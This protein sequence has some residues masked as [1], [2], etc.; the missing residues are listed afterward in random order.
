MPCNCIPCAVTTLTNCCCNY[1]KK[2]D[3]IY[4]INIFHLLFK[5]NF[6]FN[7]VL[8]YYFYVFFNI[9]LLFT[10]KINLSITQMPII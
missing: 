4:E 8:C 1:K 3:F 10:L 6:F 9:I 2:I 5:K 7:I